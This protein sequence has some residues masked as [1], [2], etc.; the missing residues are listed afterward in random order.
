[1]L[2]LVAEERNEKKQK[3]HVLLFYVFE[4]EGERPLK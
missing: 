2:C 3:L 4:R 1:M